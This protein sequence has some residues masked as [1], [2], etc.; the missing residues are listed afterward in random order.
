[1]STE[2]KNSDRKDPLACADGMPGKAL[3]NKKYR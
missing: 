1:M 3:T 2:G